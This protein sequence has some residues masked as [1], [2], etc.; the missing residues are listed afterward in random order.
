M[1]SWTSHYPTLTL[2]KVLA[3]WFRERYKHFLSRFVQ[4]F[5]GFW[6]SVGISRVGFTLTPTTVF[7][8]NHSLSF[9]KLTLQFDEVF[10]SFPSIPHFTLIYFFV[11]G[12]NVC[13]SLC[14]GSHVAK[15]IFSNSAK[16]Y[17]NPIPRIHRVLIWSS[18]NG[19]P[20]SWQSDNAPSWSPCFFIGQFFLF[21]FD[22]IFCIIKLNSLVYV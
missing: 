11:A 10:R 17:W 1:F 15:S 9:L 6:P 5:E 20:L 12:R 8:T 3:G 7:G 2:L 21:N 14:G 16:R 22:F 4:L 18:D 13:L 19:S